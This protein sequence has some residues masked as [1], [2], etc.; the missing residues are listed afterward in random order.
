MDDFF[1]LEE[2]L[3]KSLEKNGD[4]PITISH[5]LNILRMI[6]RVQEEDAKYDYGCFDNQ[7]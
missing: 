7:F 2:I 1:I 3:E 5:L 4:K 6:R